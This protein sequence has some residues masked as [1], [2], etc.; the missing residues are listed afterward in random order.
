MI[1]PGAIA[2]AWTTPLAGSSLAR[3][4]MALSTIAIAV[5]VRDYDAVKR[6]RGAPWLLFA[7]TA[8]GVYVAV[9]DTE[10][11]RVLLGVAVPFVLLSVPKPV[12][13]L[14]PAGSAAV[15]GLFVW[16]VF[17]GGRGR[18]VSVL[19]ALATIG[20]L[21]AEPLGRRWSRA[22]VAR[23]SLLPTTHRR[24]ADEYLLMATVVA[25]AQFA[26]VIFAS[27]MVAHQESMLRAWVMLVPVAIAAAFVAPMLYPEAVSR[28]VAHAA[29]R[30]S[31]RRSSSRSRSAS[32]SRYK[33]PRRS[34]DRDRRR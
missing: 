2:L 11:A 3:F 4:A 32:S 30:R 10:L 22:V 20:I 15:V 28:D 14:G 13:P 24:P 25:I 23:R 9:P 33:S 8:F 7:V 34:S 5:A 26:F 27:R 12:A 31:S 16:V 21:V 19:G 1:A 6:A 18:P 17:V 29:R